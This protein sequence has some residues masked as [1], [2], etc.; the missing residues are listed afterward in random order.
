MALPGRVRCSKACRWVLLPGLFV[1]HRQRAFVLVQDRIGGYVHF[2]D[3]NR[4]IV[5]LPFFVLLEA[6]ERYF[7]DKPATAITPEMLSTFLDPKRVNALLD[8]M[9]ELQEKRA[10]L[11]NWAALLG[12]KELLMCAREL[13][14]LK[15][16]VS[17]LDSLSKVRNLVCHAAS[18]E[19]LV[20]K[21][22]HVR[23]LA[24]AKDFCLRLLKP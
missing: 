5:Q 3:L 16:K 14:A 13:G 23:R 17:E 21:Y 7:F 19:L 10:N 9:S 18:T 20:E 12:F 6:V 11:N 1:A 15:A 22:S 2:S 8:K 24:D 4:P